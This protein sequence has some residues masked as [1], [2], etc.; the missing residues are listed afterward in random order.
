MKDAT[1]RAL[2]VFGITS[3][4]A[5]WVNAAGHLYLG[6]RGSS[7]VRDYRATLSYKSALAGD[8]TLLPL[9]TVLLDQQLDE[10]GE[11]LRPG[12]VLPGR[13][14]RAA[15]VAATLTGIVHAYQAAQKLTNW[16]MPRSWHWNFLGYYHAL[17]MT[18]QFAFL[19]YVGGAALARARVKGPGTLV[20]PRTTASLG[21]M[22][23]F[24]ALLYKDY[25]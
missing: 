6:W 22:G 12:Q 7:L 25:Y 5:F 19:G 20:T 13:L 8:S 9:L 1:A 2:V 16:T 11:G 14:A 3:V 18:G 10:W 15:G 23:L 21:L 24:A 4:S 17:Y